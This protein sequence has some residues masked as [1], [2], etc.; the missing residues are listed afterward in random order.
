MR[1]ALILNPLAIVCIMLSM[2]VLD[3]VNVNVSGIMDTPFVQEMLQV[4]T[5]QIDPDQRLGDTPSVMITEYMK[6]L[7][8]TT[9]WN[10]ASFPTVQGFLRFVLYV[11]LGVALLAVVGLVAAV[12]NLPP[13][14]VQRIG[15]AQIVV[16]ALS[17]LALFFT[18]SRIRVFGLDPN[19]FGSPATLAGISLTIGYYV[20]LL[21][22]VISIGAGVIAL[23]TT[24]SSTMRR[25]A[26]KPPRKPLY[27]R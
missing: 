12:G 27:K 17:F 10:L 1:L 23:Q 20:A 16:A 25:S 4:A 13:L 6:L 14:V 2:F 22:L 19:L 24:S 26:K 18:A 5:A 15:L 11:P 21:G 3:W 9:G 7:V 8:S